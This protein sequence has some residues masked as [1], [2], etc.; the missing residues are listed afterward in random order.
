MCLVRF[1]FGVTASFVSSSLTA[2]A[3]KGWVAVNEEAV[4]AFISAGAACCRIC[5][6]GMTVLVTSTLL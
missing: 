6:G 3:G 2:G 4:D 1:G 5:A